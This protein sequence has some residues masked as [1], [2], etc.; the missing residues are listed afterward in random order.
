M[1]TQIIIM[2]NA[3]FRLYYFIYL[4]IVFYLLQYSVQDASYLSF[5]DGVRGTRGDPTTGGIS[6]GAST[7]PT[8]GEFQGKE[9]PLH[10]RAHHKRFV[11][12]KA[13]R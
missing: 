4:S 1:H 9:H 6:P 11:L 3:I 12:H 5:Q 13:I 7:P 2:H 10:R 8:E